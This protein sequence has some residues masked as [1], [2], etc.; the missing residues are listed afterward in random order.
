MNTN[1]TLSKRI[2]NMSCHK[3]GICASKS[4]NG[5]VFLLFFLQA[6][7]GKKHEIAFETYWWWWCA[8]LH[9]LRTA[10]SIM[11]AYI[12]AIPC[13][14]TFMPYHVTYTARNVIHTFPAMWHKRIFSYF[15]E[16]NSVG[17]IMILY[18]WNTHLSGGTWAA[19]IRSFDWLCQ[20]R[21]RLVA[22][23][24]LQWVLMLELGMAV[25][26]VIFSYV[27]IPSFPYVTCC[28]RVYVL[29]FY[30]WLYVF[31]HNSSMGARKHNK[32]TSTHTKHKEVCMQW[33]HLFM[34]MY[35]YIH[36]CCRVTCSS[37][38]SCP[39]F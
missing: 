30:I 24:H 22:R 15:L 7:R 25:P 17:M 14:H 8:C 9:V 33:A 12:H 13:Y 20:P 21:E 37:M 32:H 19:A 29:L 6:C 36:V 18:I 26:A 35:F 16:G 28:S 3:S 1:I 38:G 10:M 23:W 27:F 39:C 5:L 11:Y 31:V 2:P 4:D 34:H